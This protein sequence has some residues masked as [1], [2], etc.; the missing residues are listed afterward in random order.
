MQAWRRKSFEALFLSKTIVVAVALPEGLWAVIVPAPNTEW[1]TFV[2]TLKSWNSV[3][4]AGAMGGSLGVA[5]LLEFA[6][7]EG[8]AGVYFAAVSRRSAV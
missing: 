7:L 2:P 1:M 8:F 3:D 6:G 4:S 5:G